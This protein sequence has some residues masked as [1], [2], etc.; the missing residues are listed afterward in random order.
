MS[1]VPQSFTAET[2]CFYPFAD[3]LFYPNQF[4]ASGYDPSLLDGDI[5]LPPTV[6]ENLKATKKPTAQQ[7]LQVILK[8]LAPN[9]TTEQINYIN[10]YGNLIK[11]SDEYLVQILDALDAAGL[12]DDTI[13]IKTADHGEMGLSHGGLIQKNFNMY[14]ESI[15]VP[16]V[17]SNP[18]LFP[19]PVVSQSLVSH[20]DMVPT[21]ANLFEAPLGARADW[22]GVDYSPVILDPTKSVQDYTVF[23]YDDFQSGQANG[24]YPQPPQHVRAIREARY[25]F[26]QYYDAS[27]DI[28][29]TPS[30]FEMYGK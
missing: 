6:N 18:K 30:Q 3:V 5:Q 10:F 21:F 1:V 14:E 13:V 7:Q 12:T 19:K 4:E 16:L 2:Q 26:A 25:K 15:K 9:G 17:Y 23:T 27:A 11:K 22:S 28:R 29:K 8:G 24:P 20:V